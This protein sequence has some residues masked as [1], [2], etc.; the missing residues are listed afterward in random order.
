MILV[1]AVELRNDPAVCGDV[2]FVG[3]ERILVALRPQRS[4]VSF[5]SS[6]EKKETRHGQG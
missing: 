6:R 1:R 5:V 4:R 2:E 3:A